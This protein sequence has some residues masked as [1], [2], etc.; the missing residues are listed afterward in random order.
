MAR[1]GSGVIAEDGS[2]FPGAVSHYRSTRLAPELHSK[3][4]RGNGPEVVPEYRA[5]PLRKWSGG[6]FWLEHRPR[7]WLPVAAAFRSPP[8]F[9]RRREPA[10]VRTVGSHSPGPARHSRLSGTILRRPVSGASC[11]SEWGGCLQAPGYGE[12]AACRS[13]RSRR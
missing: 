7:T 2:R 5:S 12:C 6:P 4:C 3:Q 10:A 8:R 1:Y 13:E 9:V 11:A